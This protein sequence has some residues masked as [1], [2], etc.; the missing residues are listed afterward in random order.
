MVRQ[1][2]T[3]RAYRPGVATVRLTVRSGRA[4][5]PGPGERLIAESEPRVAASE[6][7]PRPDERVVKVYLSPLP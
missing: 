4:D 5:R 7:D 1:L 6:R 2:G 3:D